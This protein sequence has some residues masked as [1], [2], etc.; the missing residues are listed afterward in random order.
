MRVFENP[1]LKDESILI[2]IA[3]N[4]PNDDYCIWAVER[5]NDWMF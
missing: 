2:D 1:N 4:A 5:I 3:K